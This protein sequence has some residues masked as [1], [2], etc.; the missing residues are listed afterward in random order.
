MAK[1]LASIKDKWLAMPIRERVFLILSLTLS[2]TLLITAATFI[3]SCISIYSAG[4][5]QPYTRE[6]VNERL[7]AILPLNLLTVLGVV[8]IGVFSLFTNE[9][10]S[11]SARISK[12]ALLKITKRSLRGATPSETHNSLKEKEEKTR[13]I[14]LISVIALSVVVFAVAAFFVLDTRRYQSDDFN[15]DIAYSVIIALTA[16]LIS[17]GS[18]FAGGILRDRS[19]E[20]EIESLRGEV[21]ALRAKGLIGSVAEATALGDGHAVLLL[22]LGIIALAITFIIVGIFNGGMSDVLGKAVRICTECIGLG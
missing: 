17:F 4:G 5:S 11:P 21:K 20:R 8:G 1:P 7:S 13:R 22:R 6:I 18:V 12:A 14:I 10:G 16:A 3:A 2:L 19:Y 15:T 9:K